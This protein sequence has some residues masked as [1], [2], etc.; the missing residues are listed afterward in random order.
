MFQSIVLLDIFLKSFPVQAGE[1][2]DKLFIVNED[3]GGL[4]DEQIASL[5]RYDFV[6]KNTDLYS[7][8]ILS[9]LKP[10]GKLLFCAQLHGRLTCVF[11]DR[12]KTSEKLAA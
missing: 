10:R 11:I 12:N 7:F 4:S 2:K 8:L 3:D 1:L 6:P 5:R 9:Q